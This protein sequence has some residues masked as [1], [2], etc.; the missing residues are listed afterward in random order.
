[1][2]E[3]IIPIVLMLALGT[4]W[5][6]QICLTRSRVIPMMSPIC[7]WVY[8]C[9]RSSSNSLSRALVGGFSI[10]FTAVPTGFWI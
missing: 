7:S 6:A 1:M 10:W 2:C 5:L 8:P 3:P 9:L 4:P